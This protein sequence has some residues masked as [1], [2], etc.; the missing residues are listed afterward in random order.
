MYELKKCAKC[1]KGFIASRSSQKYCSTK[2]RRNAIKSKRKRTKVHAKFLDKVCPVCSKTFN[3]N[4]THKVFCDEEC[5]LQHKSTVYTKK[6]IEVRTC[7]YCLKEFET[8]HTRKKYCCNECY[9][10]AQRD[11]RSNV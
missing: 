9:L 4:L 3:T 5:Y 10:Q 11:K 7:L 6:E 2:C 1:K 8:T